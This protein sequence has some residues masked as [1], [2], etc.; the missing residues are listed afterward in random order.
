MIA[1]T[2]LDGTP[3]V[4]NVDVVQ[5]IEETPDTVVALINGERLLVRE[6]AGEIVRRAVAFKRAV[7]AGPSVRDTVDGGESFGY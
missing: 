6:A 4:V 5:W 3:I 7:A 1:V 2:R